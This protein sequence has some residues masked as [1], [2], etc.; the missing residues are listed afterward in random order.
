MQALFFT[1]S[2]SPGFFHLLRAGEG[3]GDREAAPEAP[4]SMLLDPS[5]MLGARWCCSL[6]ATRCRIPR[7]VARGLCISSRLPRP[8]FSPQADSLLRCN[9]VGNA[10]LLSVHPLPSA[11]EARQM[12]RVPSDVS[13]ESLYTLCYGH[14]GDCIM[15]GPAFMRAID[16][17]STHPSS[18]YPWQMWKRFARRCVAR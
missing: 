14:K 15:L 13:G 3:A 4:A 8:T 18:T 10:D 6:R 1:E 16:A 9:G 7:V 11:E 5:R 2:T 17:S 12:P